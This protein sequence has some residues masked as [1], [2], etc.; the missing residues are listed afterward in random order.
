MTVTMPAAASISV[1]IP[2]HNAALTLARCLESVFRSVVPAQVI[3]VDDGSTDETAQIAARIAARI[4]AQ[5]AAQTALRFPCEVLQLGSN[6]GAAAARNRGARQARGEI[7]FFLDGD[8]VMEPQTLERITATF[9]REPQLAAL[10]GSYQ[11]ETAPTNF[12][13]V[14]KNLLHHYTHQISSPDA[15]TFCGGYGAVRAQIF[16]E[17]NGFDESWRALEDI[18]FGCRMYQKGYP[19]RLDRDLQ[20]THLKTYTLA[21]L[22]RS[23]V[24]HRAIPWTRLMLERRIFRNDLNTRATNIVSVVVSFLI[25]LLIPVGVFVPILWFAFVAAVLVLIWLNAPFLAFVQRR[26]GIWFALETVGMTWLNYL[27]SGIGLVLGIG[28][29]LRS[30]IARSVS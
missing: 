21:S 22:I 17:L 29:Y 15:A 13:S 18:E 25:L 1:I 27:Y 20:F 4:A 30:R 19:I 24:F 14:Y 7:L 2:V 9:A 11:T 26:R 10:F 3:V 5:F 23:D 28:V 12:V 6:A 16:W 8:I